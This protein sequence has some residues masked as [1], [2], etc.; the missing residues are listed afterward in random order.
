MTDTKK[1]QVLTPSSCLAKN[2]KSPLFSSF[3]FALPERKY[4]IGQE[5]LLNQYEAIKNYKL[6]NYNTT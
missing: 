2:D 1:F 6:I 5:T 4:H 3:T